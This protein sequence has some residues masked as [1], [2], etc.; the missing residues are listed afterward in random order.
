MYIHSRVELRYLFPAGDR[1]KGRYYRVPLSF[2][3]KLCFGEWGPDKTNHPYSLDFYDLICKICNKAN[4]EHCFKRCATCHKLYI[5][6]FYLTKYCKF[7]PT[8]W[9]CIQKWPTGYT[10]CVLDTRAAAYTYSLK[11]IR[12]FGPLGLNP[13]IFTEDELN[14]IDLDRYLSE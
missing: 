6:D 4:I 11:W 13:R 8:C 3:N 9:N 1:D 14:S 7:F 10:Y 2:R 5:V 12:E